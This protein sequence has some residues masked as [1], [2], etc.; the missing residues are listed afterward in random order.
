MARSLRL[1]N[2]ELQTGT[3]KPKASCW[4][5]K[6]PRLAHTQRWSRTAHGKSSTSLSAGRSW[7]A[8]NGR[9]ELASKTRSRVSGTE[10]HTHTHAAGSCGASRNGST[11]DLGRK[12][13]SFRTLRCKGEMSM[14][15]S[16]AVKSG[17]RAEWHT[18]Y[19]RIL[20]S[21]IPFFQG[22]NSFQFLHTFGPHCCYTNTNIYIYISSLF[23][24][25]CLCLS[26]EREILEFIIFIH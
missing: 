4:N 19:V 22:L 20:P 1:M 7:Q 16:D 10:C 12:S 9:P 26:Q 8:E 5:A 14:G 24:Y 2:K 18:I 25:S 3:D 17:F 11:P 21:V 13:P 15:S 23:L 6:K